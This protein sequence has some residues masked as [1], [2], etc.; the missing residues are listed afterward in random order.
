MVN[1]GY[2]SP[3]FVKSYISNNPNGSV[4]HIYRRESVVQLSADI[5]WKDRSSAIEMKKHLADFSCRK[6]SRL[7]RILRIQKSQATRIELSLECGEVAKRSC[8]VFIKRSRNKS[9]IIGKCST[10][11]LVDM[12]DDFDFL[13]ALM[14]KSN[15]KFSLS[16]PKIFL[17]NAKFLD[18]EDKQGLQIKN[19]LA[20]VFGITGFVS[21][22]LSYLIFGEINQITVVAFIL[23]LAFWIGSI[24]FTSKNHPNYILIQKE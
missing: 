19:V 12:V 22:A 15:L 3:I 18:D 8:F 11:N 20:D 6:K 16:D 7:K 13:K 24:V 10:N 2:T 4:L 1:K 23:G 9:R 5:K 17:D 21:G 14:N